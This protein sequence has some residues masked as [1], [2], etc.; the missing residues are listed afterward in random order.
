MKR[1]LTALVGVP[2]VSLILIF[3]N[4][5]L[6]S[7]VIGIIAIMCLREYFA[8]FKEIANPMRVIGYISCLFIFLL[9]WIKQ[10]YIRRNI[11]NSIT[12]NIVN[13]ICNRNVWKKA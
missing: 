7:F 2:V 3:G 13:I 12:Y 4:Y 6:I 5:Y 8:A 9:P 1:W 10:E 11:S